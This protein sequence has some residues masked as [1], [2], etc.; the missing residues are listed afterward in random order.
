MQETFSGGIF[1]F[2]L[3]SLASHALALSSCRGKVNTTLGRLQRSL[4]WP[5][6]HYLALLL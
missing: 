1:A 2:I 6:I 4:I 3:F 5:Q